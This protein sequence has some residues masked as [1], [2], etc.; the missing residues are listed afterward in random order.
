MGNAPGIFKVPP[1]GIFG[2]A[3][4]AFLCIR[5]FYLIPPD[6]GRW[7]SWLQ[8]AVVP[9]FGIHL[10]VVCAWWGM[11]RWINAAATPVFCTAAAWGLSL[12]LILRII[13]RRTGR[14]VEKKT[15]LLRLPAA[16][17]VFSWLAAKDNGPSG[18]LVFYAAAFALPYLVL[19]AQQYLKPGKIRHP[20]A[21]PLKR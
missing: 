9:V 5:K 13:R 8:A 15:L 18:Y 1:V 17:F 7:A 3:C 21:S 16:A 6:T 11:F 2:W 19:M 14:G 20:A 10:L 4:F 12:L